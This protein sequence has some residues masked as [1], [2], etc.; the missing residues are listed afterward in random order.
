MKFR[1]KLGAALLLVVLAFSSMPM[2]TQS[3][4]AAT[5]YWAQFVADVTIPDGTNFA[6]GTA[7][8]KT[9]RL[10]N[11]GSCAWNTNDVSLIFKSGEQMGAPA[12][13]ALSTTVNPGQTVDI[14]VGMTSPGSA[15]HFFG[16]YKFRSASGGEFGI[17]GTAN[18]TFWVEINV[19]SSS[20]SGTGYDFTA[21]ASSA[22]WSGGSGS[23]GFPGTDGNASGFGLK[24]DHPKFENGIES[25][26][27]G[28]LFGPNNVNNGYIQASY[29]AFRVQSGDRFQSMIGCEYGATNCYVAYRLD[30]Q[31]GSSGIRTFW[32]FREKYEGL[33]YN[34]N[35]DLSSLA[36]QDVQFIL[37]VS[38]YGSPTGDRALWGNPI[39]ARAGGNTGPTY[40]PTPT[41]T[42]TPPTPTPTGTPS[43][44]PAACDRAQFISDVTVPDGTTFQPN[45]TFSKTWRLKNIGTCTWTSYSLMF[46][47]GEKMAGPD[48]A[49]ISAS[50]A[51]GQTVDISINLTA[52]AGGG[53][54]RGYWKLKNNNGIPFGIGSG[55][56]KSFWVEIRVTGNPLTP[57]PTPTPTLGTPVTP[58][59][60]IS[61]TVYDFVAN[62][63][64]A[65]WYSGAG[66]LP[67][68]G[69]D[70]DAKGFVLIKNPSRLENGTNDSRSGLLTYP[71]NVTNGYI[72]GIYPSYKV[73]SGDK[74][75]SVV[76][77]ENGA[78]S[79]YV[80]FRLDYSV[81]GSS[82]VQTYWA[83]VERYEGQVYNADIDLGPL[84]GQDLKFILTILSTGSPVGDR[85]LWVAPI[86]FNA[87]SSS[88]TSTPTP[89]PTPTGVLAPTGTPT[90]T[91]TGSPV[92]TATFT[93]TPTPTP[94]GTTTPAVY[95]YDF[96][97]ASSPVSTGYTRVTET[98]V[99]AA[100]GFGWTDASTLES[101]DRSALADDLKRD[102]VL[103]SSAPRSFKVDLPNGNYSI[104]TTMGDNDYAHDNMIVKAN[105]VTALADVDNALG[106]FTANTF[107][108]TV[109]GGSLTLE[110]SDAGGADPTWVVNGLTITKLP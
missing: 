69:T 78:T 76:N 45:S 22:T 95:K 62:V 80:V 63:C 106:A 37:V 73:K 100:G 9:W 38:A 4:R 79:C 97:T 35:L 60:P 55:G 59:T 68:P 6:A 57:T 58:A 82:S 104:A 32:T 85:A 3:V 29:P 43:Q 26:Q 89:T 10:K 39:I 93:P 34:V 107:T 41:V 36:G 16:Y 11:I 33:S 86:I 30:Y 105:G 53:T 87:G 61:G 19:T 99:Y 28:L 103:S 49:L 52:P 17:G 12:S 56:T 23:L 51:P 109:S 81:S 40:T 7:F 72:Q 15:G 1:S 91:P 54:F 90:P 47:S 83:F 65:N 2:S 101:R 50:V 108:A 94:T 14:S 42:G 67:C 70:G 110:F 13:S 98:T 18:N 8:T 96:G 24:K 27:A 77:C 74:F 5:C 64:A 92:P 20:G 44:G 21:N 84:V 46:D 66:P 48:S 88:S 25:N 31:I 75:R 102:L 71:Q